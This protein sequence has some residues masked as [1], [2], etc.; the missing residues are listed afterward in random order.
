M[1]IWLITYGLAPAESFETYQI[2]EPGNIIVRTTDLR[3][4]ERQDEPP[5]RCRLPSKG[6]ASDMGDIVPTGAQDSSNTML[7][8]SI[9]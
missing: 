3:S 5:R 7:E 8:S 4:S 6:L 9:L 2:V 1:D